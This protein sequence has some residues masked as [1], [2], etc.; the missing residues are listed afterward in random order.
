LFCGRNGN[1]V[2]ALGIVN[3]IS[4]IK[5]FIIILKEVPISV[6]VGDKCLKQAKKFGISPQVFD[7]VYGTDAD[8]IFDTFGYKIKNN[9]ARAK[10]TLSPGVRGCVAS[11]I[12]LLHKCIQDDVPFLILEHDSYMIRELPSNI[13]LGFSDVIKLDPYQPFL[14]DYNESA[15][16]KDTLSLS[17]KE[18]GFTKYKRPN[19]KGFKKNR[20]LGALFDDNGNL[21][22]ADKTNYEYF[23]GTY[24]HIVKPSGA[25]K[26]IS[27]IE[28]YGLFPADWLFNGAYLDLM[29]TSKTIVRI[30]PEYNASECKEKKLS[31]TSNLGESYDTKRQ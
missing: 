12:L 5:S 19:I 11:H 3:N 14:S 7:G 31:T 2:L 9:R 20:T 17:E 16:K 10:M 18:I 22:K 24:G 15:E 30:H 4:D 27:Y 21:L 13:L 29:T 25:K 6:E 23:S 1:G 8:K 26:I 28:E